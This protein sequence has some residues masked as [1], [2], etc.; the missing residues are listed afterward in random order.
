MTALN[1]ALRVDPERPGAR[2]RLGLS[3]AR[4]GDL[5]G[6]REAFRAVLE[7]ADAPQSELARAELARLEGL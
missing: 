5:D 2:Y 3:L 7:T 4:K 1:G 6:A